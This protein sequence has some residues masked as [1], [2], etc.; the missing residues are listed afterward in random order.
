M[1]EKHHVPVSRN[2]LLNLIDITVVGAIYILARLL[3]TLISG[4]EYK[5]STLVADCVIALLVYII[6]LNSF[7]VNKIIW[8]YSSGRDYFYL[9]VAAITCG[10]V[11]CLILEVMPHDETPVIYNLL[12]FLF[13]SLII[14]FT[15][16]AYREFLIGMHKIDTGAK[17]LLIVGAGEAGS[18]MVEEILTN[19]GSGLNPVGFIDDDPQKLGRSI[20]GVKVLG[21]VSDIEQICEE[22]GIQLIYI[23]IPSA[24]NEIRATILDECSKTNCSVKILPYYSAIADDN[25]SFINKV[26]DITPEELLGREPIK[27]AD[28]EIL[29]FVKDK[30]VAI[31]GGGGSIGSELCRQIAAYSPKRLIIIDVYENTTYSIQQELRARFKELDLNVYIAT[32]CDYNKI[33]S[34]FADEKP[35]IVIHAAAHKHVPLMETVP[36][37]CV[38]NNVFGTLN[39]A[40]A[41]KNNGAEKFILISTDKAVNPT[42]IMGATKRVCEMIIQYVD[43]ISPNTTFAAVRFGN[44]LGSHGSVIPLFKKQIENRNDV[45]VTH[46]EMI[47]YFMTIPEAS[48]LVLTASAMAK[49]G[50]IFVLDMGEPVKIDDLARK[51]INLSGLIIG[52]DI[53]I[54]YIGLRPGEKLYEELLMSEEGL[55]KTPNHKIFIGNLIKMDYDEFKDQLDSLHNLVNNESV[56]PSEVESMLMDIVPTFHRFVESDNKTEDKKEVVAV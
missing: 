32:V 41:T 11:S 55:R 4:V 9:F 8:R 30:T 20:R 3:S 19:P 50:E 23:A 43:S 14:T 36:D 40:L 2:F 33:N 37:E 29:S 1:K 22:N 38:K 28:E 35:D 56:E 54:K 49:G 26:R 6:G 42:N 5:L 44:V 15:R 39:T 34:I 47:R 27:V 31:T 46:P 12:A 18:R 16:V 48:Q 45:T 51:M 21:G 53:N 52:K 17:R 24:S 10:I 7:G 13:C 25:K